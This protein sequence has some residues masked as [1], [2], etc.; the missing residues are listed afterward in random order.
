MS[1][2]DLGAEAA[3]A[4]A[5]PLVD[6]KLLKTIVIVSALVPAGLLVWDALHGQ[7]GA[8]DVNFAIRSTGMLGLVFMSLSLVITPLRRLTGYAPLL[9]IRRN[10]GV[11]GFLYILT[12]FL[13]FVVYDRAGSI[14]STVHEIIERQY[15]WFGFAALVIMTPLAITSFDGMV[16]K[17]GPK[18]WKLLHR[19]AY[20]AV[21][22]GVV[23]FYLLVKADTTNPVAF[24]VVFGG[25]MTYR[26][27]RHYFD[28][29]GEV[30][31]AKDKLAAAKKAGPA[32]KKFWS[33]EL[34]VARIFDETH[35][36]K[37]FRMVP[38]AGGALPF[39]AIAGQYINLA[40]TIDG[41]RV[42]RS[43]TIASAPTRSHYVEISV[44]RDGLASKHLH[45]SLKQGD[46][47]KVGAPAGKFFFAGHEAERVVLVAGGVG[48]TPMM[49]VIRSLTD[50]GWTGD[51]Y[52]VFAVKTRADIIFEKELALLQ[53]R[54]PN[55]HVVVTLTGEPA[56]SPWTGARGRIDRALVEGFVPSVGSSRVMLCGPDAQMKA[57]RAL[58]V[59]LGV[60]DGQ[61]HEEE[62]VSPPAPATSAAAD[63]AMAPPVDA[64]D[65]SGAFT[66]AFKRAGKT[67]DVVGLTVLEAAEDNDVT[68]PFE[69]RSG[70]CGQ[71][72][73]KLVSGRVVMEAQ[74]ALSAGDRAKGLILACQARPVQNC[75]IDV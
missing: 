70:I 52:L 75:E 55:L 59:S 28:L 18:R 61:V 12:H 58:F 54:H 22:C 49:S 16:T 20:V 9:G 30:K 51:M 45:A 60:P 66:V 1:I 71:C 32:K 8:N 39:E 7:L 36:V 6:G 48:I 47:I 69:C 24:G 37:T 53:E 50:R 43:Y 13:I 23:H 2:S 56:D 27:G 72:K 46:T 41:K 17:L 31:Q 40:L 44:K 21:L 67:A 42:N 74:D 33:G 57:A 19:L 14:A 64:G 68:I 4:P 26:V 3:R 25:L 73:C 65:P 63:A 11:Y 34:R 15:L 10:L 35:N 38:L 29:R 62:F 5:P